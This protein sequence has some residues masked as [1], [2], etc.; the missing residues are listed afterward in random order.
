MKLA[1]PGPW[2]LLGKTVT[3]AIHLQLVCAH[4]GSLAS[5]PRILPR[6][7]YQ[8]LGYPSLETFLVDYWERWSLSLDANN[9]LAQI[10]SWQQS[11][12]SDNELYEL[13]FEAA[14]A[15]ITAR[16][17]VLPCKTDTYFPPEDSQYEVAHMPN[18]EL[19]PIPSIWGHWARGGRNP[20]DTTFIDQALRGLLAS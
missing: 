8:A 16:T 19:R 6:E 13:H 3:I 17:I 18:A 14:L 15:S 5:L 7:K 9:I 11:N 12:I 20:V 10:W 4:L 1:N 2:I